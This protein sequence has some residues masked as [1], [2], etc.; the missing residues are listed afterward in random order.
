MWSPLSGFLCGV[1]LC[2]SVSSVVEILHPSCS[3]VVETFKTFTT[4][5]TELYRGT[6]QRQLVLS[7]DSSLSSTELLR[8]HI[9]PPFES[10]NKC[11]RFGIAQQISNFTD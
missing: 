5:N 3:L 9:V 2:N 10:A 11:R 1:A 7:S 4:E 8:S 6:P